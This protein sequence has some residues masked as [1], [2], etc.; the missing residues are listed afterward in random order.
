MTDDIVPI[1]FILLVA[2]IV[3]GAGWLINIDQTNA[4]Q[5]AEHCIAAGQQWVN[6]SCVN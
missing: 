6:G 4:Q 1:M 3:A 2:L 5:L